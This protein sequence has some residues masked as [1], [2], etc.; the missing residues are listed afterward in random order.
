[1]SI[2]QYHV[3]AGAGATIS[4][5]LAHWVRALTEF[6]VFINR[7]MAAAGNVSNDIAPTLSKAKGKRQKLFVGAPS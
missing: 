5:R 1:M 2:V 6:G 3:C 4:T 7:N